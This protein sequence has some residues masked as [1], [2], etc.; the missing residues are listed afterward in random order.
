MQSI[1][2]CTFFFFSISRV[3]AAIFIEREHMC[4]PYFCRITKMLYTRVLFAARFKVKYT[5]TW[6]A[7]RKLGSFQRNENV[8]DIFLFLLAFDRLFLSCIV[9]LVLFFFAFLFGASL[10]HDSVLSFFLS[11]VNQNAL[12]IYFNAH[13]SFMGINCCWKH[14]SISFFVVF[15]VVTKNRSMFWSSLLLF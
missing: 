12:W 6:A 8:V 3:V 14:Y 5:N 15:F 11:C 13:Y 10:L 7:K 4:S 2:W 9:C 1:C